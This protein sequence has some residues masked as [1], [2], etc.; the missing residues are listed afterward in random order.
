M[1][2]PSP[3]ITLDYNPAKDV[4]IVEWPDI[5]EFSITEVKHSLQ[6][7]INTVKFYDVKN[8]LVDSRKAVIGVSK[9]EYTT[10][11]SGFIKELSGTRIQK[12]ARLESNNKVKEAQVKEI[13]P[14]ITAIAFQNFSDFNEALR[15]LDS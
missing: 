9:E 7:I 2:I 14:L 5:Q 10:I 12:V 8:L 13:S 11:A 1:I 4:L 3:L 15:W 6:D